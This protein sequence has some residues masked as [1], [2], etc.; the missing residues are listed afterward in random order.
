MNLGLYQ[1]KK[2]LKYQQTLFKSDDDDLYRLDV[3]FEKYK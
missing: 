3:K 1:S 2:Y